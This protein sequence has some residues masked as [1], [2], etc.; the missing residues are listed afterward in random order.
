MRV[1]VL[2]DV[3]GNLPALELALEHALSS[4]AERLVCLGD[5]VTGP[6]PGGVVDLLGA[7]RV[8]CVRGNM[9][10][11]VLVA[12]SA[13]GPVDDRRFAEIDA[14][15]LERLSAGQRA[16]LASL[17]ATALLDLGGGTRL[18][19]CH[20]SPV[21]PLDAIGPATPDDE[22]RALLAGIEA[23]LVA[24]GHLHA[25]M[26]RTLDGVTVLNPGS[27][28]WPAPGPRGRRPLQ[29]SYALVEASHEGGSHVAFHR[30]EIDP[31]SFR[32]RALAS[33]M[34]HSE[35][36]LGLWEGR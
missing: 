19:A 12:G 27:V 8:T 21:S 15:C 6:F 20:G 14:W 4:G 24:V 2:T 26:L 36:Y 17:P 13:P 7:H 33:G 25:P 1:A 10:E 35:W 29:A 30:L 9:D 34:P 3:Q 11:A 32:R 5:L 28:G 23:E 22:V 18:L 31:G 16:Y